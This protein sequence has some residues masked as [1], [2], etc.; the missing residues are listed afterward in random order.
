[1]PYLRICQI[2]R[3]DR[4]KP[5][6][7]IPYYP[8]SEGDTVSH[9]QITT[10]GEKLVADYTGL[11]FV[12]V[13]ELPIDVYMLLMRDAFIYKSERTEKGQKYLEN[14]WRM[15]QTKPDRKRLREHFGNVS[16]E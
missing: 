7:K 11:N 3:T 9:Y 15:E 8:Q 12:Q 4:K 16:C 5:K 2:C 10:I 14:C 6:L 1:M 13:E